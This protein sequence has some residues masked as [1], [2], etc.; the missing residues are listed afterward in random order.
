MKFNKVWVVALSALVLSG[1]AAQRDLA[2]GSFDYLEVEDYGS[3]NAPEGLEVPQQR[4][5]YVLPTLSAEQREGSIGQAVSVRS[6]RQV[7]TLA[8]GSRIEEGSNETRLAFDAVEGISDLPNWVWNGVVAVMGEMGAEIV[9]ESPQERIVTA[10]FTREHYQLGREGFFN[11]LRRERDQYTS[12]QVI[13][14]EMQAASHRRS[15]VIDAQASEIAWLENGNPVSSQDTP[16]MLQRELEAGV[17]NQISAYL[18]RNYSADQIADARQGVEIRQGETADG[19]SAIVFDSNF[20]VAWSLM[21]GVLESVG[22]VIE[23]FNQS[24]GIY[25]T[26]YEPAGKR[27][28]FQRLA[29]WRGTEQGELPIELGTEIE[30]NVD[31]RDGV[32]YVIPYINEEPASAESL[33]EWMPSFARAF[34]EQTQD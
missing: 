30:F 5:Q 26:I 14:I 16:I 19:F 10:R 17:L 28:F 12:E 32:I 34:R 22:F 33:A 13:T 4:S 18:A 29:F 6:P 25:Y 24:E 15:A 1:C 27:S 8:P 3:L 9:E 2:E 21:P 31:D 11:R 20:N 23:D 7:L